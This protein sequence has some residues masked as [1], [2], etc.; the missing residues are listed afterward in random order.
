MDLDGF[1]INI[2]NPGE[3]IPFDLLMKTLIAILVGPLAVGIVLLFVVSRHKNRKK[4]GKSY[5]LQDGTL[6]NAFD[7]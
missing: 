1:G 7:F 3:A 6:K 4:H 5:Q 2:T